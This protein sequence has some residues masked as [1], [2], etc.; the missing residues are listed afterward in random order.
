MGG[1]TVAAATAQSWRRGTGLAMHASPTI[2]GMLGIVPMT[3]ASIAITPD[4]D[5]YGATYDV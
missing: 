3:L 5:F 1:Y 2:D 4:F